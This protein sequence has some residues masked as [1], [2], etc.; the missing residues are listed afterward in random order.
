MNNEDKMKLKHDFL[1]SIAIINSTTK[2]VLTLLT[3]IVEK[4]PSQNLIDKYSNGLNAILAQTTKIESYFEQI[5][6]IR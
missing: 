1:N 4:T 6:K 3:M 2:S 5:L